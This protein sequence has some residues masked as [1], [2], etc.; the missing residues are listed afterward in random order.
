MIAIKLP[1]TTFHSICICYPTRLVYN[2]EYLYSFTQIRGP[3]RGAASDQEFYYDRGHDRYYEDEGYGYKEDN[4][5]EYK[6]ARAVGTRRQNPMH[7]PPQHHAHQPR[8]YA[9]PEPYARP[10]K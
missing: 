4:R 3:V 5:N 1:I 9:R 7:A 6:T 2:K 10:P 8:H